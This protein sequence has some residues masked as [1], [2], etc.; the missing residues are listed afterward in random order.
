M[1]LHL[2]YCC[3]QKGHGYH[4]DFVIVGCLVVLFSVL[5][6][7]WIVGATVKSIVHV[8]GLSVYSSYAPGKKPKFEGVVYVCVCM[9]VCVC[10][11]VCKR[12]RVMYV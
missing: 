7:P 9:C 8:Q 12:G 6:L 2:Y 3:Q 5:G 10:V 4:L 1:T 11:C